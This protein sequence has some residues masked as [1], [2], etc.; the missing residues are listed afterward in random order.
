LL[1]NGVLLFCVL[2][3]S[4][5]VLW[6]N[7]G[8]KHEPLKPQPRDNP[9]REVAANVPVQESANPTIVP[10]GNLAED[11][12]A[13]IALFAGSSSS[14]VHITTHALERDF[15]SFNVFEIPQGTG[16]GFIWDKMGHVVT[17]LHVIEDAD[18]AH[19]ALADHSTWP[20]ELV[21][22]APEKDV[23][24]LKIDAPADQ[25]RPL[26][27]GT[28]R[29]LQVGQKVFAIGNPFGLDQT[30]TTGVISAL[31]R[32][33]ESRTGRPI[34]DVIQ[35]DAAINPGNSG[36]PLLD[37]TGRLIGVNT[38]IFSPSGAYAGIGFAIPVDTVAWAVPE[39][40]DHGKI[41]RPG[42]RITV[43]PERWTERLDLQGVLIMSVEG[44]S[45]AD[46]AGLRST[47]RDRFGNVY[48]G[49]VIVA[50]D[51]LAVTSAGDLLSAFER[52]K[53]G[54]E[55]EL[56]VLRDEERTELPAQLEATD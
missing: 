40:I 47:R 35:T 30:L 16:T 52:H 7:L 54:D 15:F 29:D 19:V 20:A 10:R 36:G 43:A 5:V 8:R 2:V 38:A 34:K 53:V 14:V 25:L 32:E 39:L 22:V 13:T 28:S 21:G 46:A 12:K 55:V 9:Q 44:G 41:I 27:I 56:T 18:T 51:G 24:V 37:S 4:A 48:L 50:V 11:E 33:I 17:N 26:P 6:Q 23:A 42:L 49:D 3:L 45:T 1:S 31:G